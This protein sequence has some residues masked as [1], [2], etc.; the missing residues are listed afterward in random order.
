MIID[1]VT[2][3]THKLLS[4]LVL[5]TKQATCLPSLGVTQPQGPYAYSA[6]NAREMLLAMDPEFSQV[7]CKVGQCAELKL[8]TT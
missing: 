8:Q 6:A 4:N 1:R 2:Y 7:I 5:W 3:H